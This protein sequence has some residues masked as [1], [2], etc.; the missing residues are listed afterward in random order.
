MLLRLALLGNLVVHVAASHPPAGT[1][2]NHSY[3]RLGNC[4]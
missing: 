2:A 3:P 1:Q 4:W